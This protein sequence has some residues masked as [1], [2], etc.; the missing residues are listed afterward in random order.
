MKYGFKLALI[1]LCMVC[2]FALFGCQQKDVQKDPSDTEMMKNISE[3]SGSSAETEPFYALIVGNDSRIGTVEIDKP[4]Y[5]DGTGRSDTIILARIDPKTYSITLVTVPRDTR[6]DLGGQPHKINEVYRQGGMD[7][8][9]KEVEKLTGVSV[10]YHFDMGFVEFEKFINALSGITADVPI[11]MN[12]QDIVGGNKITLKA[13]VQQLDG[14]ESLVLARV[15]KLYANDHDA[16]RQIQDRQIVA[17]AIQQVASNP[18][19]FDAALSALTQHSKT[20]WPADGMKATVKN[21]IDHASDISIRSGT[22]PYAGGP[23]DSAGGLWLTTR[24]ENT[25]RTLID[26]VNK[27][28][29]PVTVVALPPVAAA[30]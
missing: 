1:S 8:L 12:L 24:D 10:K 6:V 16:C 27:G 4:D 18:A 26:V 22:G 7:A 5:A 11:D 2:V 23:D 17:V 29:D 13:G 21:F 3:G 20:N 9:V 25:W 15:R 14:A 19:V 30:G 28:G